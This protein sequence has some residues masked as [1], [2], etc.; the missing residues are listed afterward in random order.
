[1]QYKF[2]DIGEKLSGHSGIAEVMD[3]LG[4]ALS[5]AGSE[6]IV[7]MGGGNPAHIPRM[8]QLW[9][10]RMREI[11]DEGGELFLESLE[12]VDRAASII[13]DIKG[14]SYAGGGRHMEADVNGLLR[15]PGRPSGFSPDSV[16]ARD[17]TPW[18]MLT[19]T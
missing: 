6:R 4:H 16:T 7:M 1:M 10:R 5:Q 14:L 13:R 8:Q 18:S 2:S 12:G 19:S 3:D 11:L 17:C 15:S 9:R